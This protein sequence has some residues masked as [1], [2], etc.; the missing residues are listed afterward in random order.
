[1]G[2]EDG[3]EGT[4]KKFDKSSTGLEVNNNVLDINVPV[5]QSVAQKS[6]RKYLTFDF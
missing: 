4:Q 5:K 1:M 3:G 2:I 6:P